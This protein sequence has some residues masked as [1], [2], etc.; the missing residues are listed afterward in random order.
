M[1]IVRQVVAML[2]NNEFDVDS[3]LN[4]VRA[5]LKGEDPLVATGELS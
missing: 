5:T 3:M 2:K 1:A 4:L